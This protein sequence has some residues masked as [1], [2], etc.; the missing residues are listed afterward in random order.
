MLL[1]TST[2]QSLY[3]RPDMDLLRAWEKEEEVARLHHLNPRILPNLQITRTLYGTASQLKLI[4]SCMLSFDCADL[5][6]ILYAPW[7]AAG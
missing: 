7:R 3:I 5:Q 1:H 6:A 2:K 4:Q